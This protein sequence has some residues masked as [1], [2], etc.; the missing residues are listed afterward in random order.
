MSADSSFSYS[1][2]AK[3]RATSDS[4]F[5]SALF[6]ILSGCTIR[7]IAIQVRLAMLKISSNSYF[8]VVGIAQRLLKMVQDS[9]IFNN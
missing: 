7:F 6:I 9:S 3:R 2:S 8:Y 5:N 4:T 1:A